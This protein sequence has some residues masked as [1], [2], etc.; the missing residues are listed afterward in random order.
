MKATRRVQDVVLEGPQPGPPAQS[1]P[2]STSANTMHILFSSISLVIL[3]NNHSY[4]LCCSGLCINYYNKIRIL[5]L[6]ILDI[7]DFYIVFNS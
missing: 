4:I 7:L 1:P 3:E 6:Y 2:A 5:L